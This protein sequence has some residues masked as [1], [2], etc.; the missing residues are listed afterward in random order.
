VSRRP[1]AP[2]V[3][4]IVVNY[5]GGDALLAC[6]ASLAEQD[7]SVELVLVDNGSSDRSA[8]RACAEFPDARLVRPGRNLGFA[9]GA[10]L[11]A[12]GARAPVLLFL[13]PDVRLA[14]GCLPSLVTALR[15]PHTGVVGPVLEVSSSGTREYGAT[16]DPLGY[17]IARIEPGRALYVPGCALATPADL[18]RRLGGFDERFFM[19]A[20]DVDYCWRSLLT[21]RDVRVVPDAL[22]FHVG[23]GSTPGGYLGPDGLSTTRFRVSL[24][25]RNTLAMLLKCHRPSAATAIALAYP[26]QA[27]ATAGA[28][29]LAGK[30]GTARAILGGLAWNVR[31]L[32]ETL[33]RRRAARSGRRP[34]DSVIRARMHSGVR[35]LELL[36]RH[37]LPR[38]D[39]SSTP[40]PAAR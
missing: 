37:G 34:P 7:V 36:V 9:G 26:V 28:L 23:G 25:E 35:K 27:L 11:G 40:T 13:N 2:A 4:A 33:A 5:E 22:A 17:P 8:A 1:S 19:F 24:R 21:G 12:A 29:A 39:D 10:N 30:R 31:E 15:D 6:L 14:S 32:P 3:T 16:I 38:V 18:F 20:E